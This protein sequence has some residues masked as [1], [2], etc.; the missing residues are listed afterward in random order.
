MRILII[1]PKT[2]GRGPLVGLLTEAGHDCVCAEDA[3]AALRVE[4]AVPFDIVLCDREL[5]PE[6]PH[7]IAALG[8]PG[9][10]RS[11]TLVTGVDFD[12][13]RATAAGSLA[14]TFRGLAVAL[15]SADART[16]RLVCND[17]I[18][19]P[20][21]CRALRRGVDLAVTKTEFLVLEC[22]VRHAGTVVTRR[23]LCD[24]VWSPDW[25]GVTNV[26]DVYISRVRRKV[27]RGFDCPLVHTIRGVGYRL[28]PAR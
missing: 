11:V 15:E 9:A 22:L 5:P 20:G 3:G 6:T 14:A 7:V 27:D 19:E 23:M 13:A 21:V 10:E 24:H 25:H 26:V 8:M 1:T 17:L 18:L 28:G 16:R 4:R 12:N 2:A